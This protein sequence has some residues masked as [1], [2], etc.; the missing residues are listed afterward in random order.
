MK[1]RRNSEIVE[2]VRVRI[3][4][5]NQNGDDRSG[6]SFARQA[7]NTKGTTEKTKACS[8]RQQDRDGTP[9][10]PP[11]LPR[12]KLQN[13]D[14]EVGRGRPPREHT[15]RPGHCPNP[16]GRPK[17]RKN[18][19]TIWKEILGRKVTLPIAGKP[20]KVTIQEAIQ[21]R[22]AN[23]ALGGNIKSA[24]FILNRFAITVTGETPA[25]D[26]N[27]DD[28]AVLEAFARRIQQDVSE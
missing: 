26:L 10:I 13:D 2:R 5:G 18:E 16:K 7:R 15:W 24:G 1:R 20:K 17:G 22:I 25:T 12:R 28:R 11:K 19:A 9:Q 8:A 4:P 6:H 3:R 27:E 14:Y 21:Y 23:D